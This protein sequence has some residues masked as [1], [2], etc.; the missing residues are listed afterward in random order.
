VSTELPPKRFALP[1]RRIQQGDVGPEQLKLVLQCNA[2]AA[3]CPP[4]HAVSRCVDFHYAKI[5]L[6]AADRFAWR[7]T[8][9]ASDVFRDHLSISEIVKRTNLAR[10][11]VKKWLKAPSNGEPRYQRRAVA[12]KL[13]AFAALLAQMLEVDARRPKRDR[14]TAKALFKQIKGDGY[15]GGYA[16]LKGAIGARVDRRH[17]VIFIVD[18]PQ[19]TA[20]A[21]SGVACH[22]FCVAR[23]RF[24]VV[25]DALSA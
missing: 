13:T 2:S 18:W 16:Q 22:T 3:R 17:M 5:C 11:T 19:S 15:A 1:G 7:L 8:C 25:P 21:V 14:R 9:A 20:V 10:N 24:H 6:V 4:C 12:H 23:T